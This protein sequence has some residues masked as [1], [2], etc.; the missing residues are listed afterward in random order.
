MAAFDPY[1]FSAMAVLVREGRA[2]LVARVEAVANSDDL[3]RLAA[4]QSVRLPADLLAD[5]A[6]PPARLREAFVAAVEQRLVHRKAV[7]GS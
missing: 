3:R 1:A 4:A 6:M 5:P 2:G 7:S